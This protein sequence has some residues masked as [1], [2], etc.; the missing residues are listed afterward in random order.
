[1]GKYQKSAAG[2]ADVKEAIRAIR[3][4][5][6]CQTRITLELDEQADHLTCRVETYTDHGARIGVCR[7]RRDIKESG[8]ALLDELQLALHRAYWESIDRATS[9]VAKEGMPRAQR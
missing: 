8:R 7:V 2:L 6:G 9:G 1:M 5:A 4:D 3:E